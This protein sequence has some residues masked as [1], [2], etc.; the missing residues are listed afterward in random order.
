M[1]FDYYQE[2]FN[3]YIKQNIIVESF[4]LNDIYILMKNQS[5]KKKDER[6]ILIQIF[7]KLPS[8]S[9]GSKKKNVVYIIEF[10]LH[11][12]T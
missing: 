9:W 5:R 2:I 8:C 7:S 3:K 12:R 11:Q 1:D 6:N 4:H 10:F